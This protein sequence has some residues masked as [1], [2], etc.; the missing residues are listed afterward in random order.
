MK[1]LYAVSLL[2]LAS[3]ASVAGENQWLYQKVQTRG[4]KGVMS[5]N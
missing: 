4:R 1:K 5:S 2:T 3:G